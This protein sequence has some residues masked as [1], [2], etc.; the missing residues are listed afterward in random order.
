MLFV[1]AMAMCAASERALSGSRPAPTNFS[2]SNS[3]RVSKGSDT[4][5]ISA[6]NLVVEAARSPFSASSTTRDDTRNVW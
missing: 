1:A 4:I 6:F 5:C 3:E 2:E